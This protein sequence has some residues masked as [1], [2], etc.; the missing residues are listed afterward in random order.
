[1]AA[2]IAELTD[3]NFKSE[4]TRNT[5]SIVD[6]YASWCGSCR[7]FAPVFQEVAAA[8]PEFKFYKIEAEQ[9]PEFRASIPI[10]NLPFV[11]VF[12]NGEYVG[13]QTTSKREALEEMIQI[14]KEKAGA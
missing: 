7:L 2:E 5:L 3:K 4:V 6:I 14:V 8:H 1:M 13:G 9:N 11:A 12:Q 10:D